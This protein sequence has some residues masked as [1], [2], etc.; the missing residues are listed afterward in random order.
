MSRSLRRRVWGERV[1]RQT[2]TDHIDPL[3][4]L[5]A[6][7]AV[8][9]LAFPSAA[10]AAVSHLATGERAYA[11]IDP[12]SGSF[13]V[14]ALV[15]TLIGAGLAVKTYWARI[16]AFLSGGRTRRESEAERRDPDE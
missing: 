12:G 5:A 14:Q 10:V 11:Y 8:A 1:T 6:A 15:A 13:L 16:R 3:T 9:A 2:V 7:L 4:R